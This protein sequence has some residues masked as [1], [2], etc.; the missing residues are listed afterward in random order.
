MKII[1]GLK[2]NGVKVEIPDCKRNDL[3]GFFK[4]MGYKVGVEIGVRNADFSLLIA[5]VGLKIYA[6]DPWM[7]YPD[8]TEKTSQEEM[9]IQ[10]E[11][12]KKRLSSY[13]CT[14]IRKTSMDAIKDFEDESLDF[15]YI[16]ANH[17]FKFVAEDIY[18]WLKKVKKGGVISGHDYGSTTNPNFFHIHVKYVV[19]AYTT[20][21]RIRKWYVLGRDEILPGEKREVWRSW[22]WIKE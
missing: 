8:Y 15:V 19:D 22:M 3:P 20:A 18:E 11:K 14:T 5:R 2:L 7:V 12:A 10:Y 1:D 16:D 21:F 13:G 9:N 17:G 4:E 6:I